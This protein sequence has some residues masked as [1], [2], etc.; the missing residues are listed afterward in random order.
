MLI[1]ELA[2]SS[3]SL[4]LSVSPSPSLCLSLS[5]PLSLPLSPLALS[6]SIPTHT[7]LPPLSPLSSSLPCF[8]LSLLLSPQLPLLTNLEGGGGG[9]QGDLM[10]KQRIGICY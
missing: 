8:F 6:L 7:S 2:N 9:G 5:L 10:N 4:S 3:C 1:F